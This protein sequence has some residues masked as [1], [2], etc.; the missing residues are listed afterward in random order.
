MGLPVDRP[1]AFAAASSLAI[2]DHLQGKL[3]MVH[4]TS[5]VNATFSATMKM[6]EALARADRPYDLVV[7]PE[8]DHHFKNAGEHQWRYMHASVARYFLEHLGAPE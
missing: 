7:L 4:G 2:A 3:L 5:D 6:C 8:A 1:E